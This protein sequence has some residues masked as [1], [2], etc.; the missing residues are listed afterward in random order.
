MTLFVLLYCISQYKGWIGRTGKIRGCN[1][2]NDAGFKEGSDRAVERHVWTFMILWR[3]MKAAVV[4]EELQERGGWPSGLWRGP[5]G[6]WRYHYLHRKQTQ[7]PSLLCACDLGAS[8][9]SDNLFLH[10]TTFLPGQLSN[11]LLSVVFVHPPCKI[12]SLLSWQLVCPFHWHVIAG[13]HLHGCLRCCTVS[14]RGSQEYLWNTLKSW[15]FTFP[16]DS[17]LHKLRHSN[18]ILS[19]WAL[20]VPKH[21]CLF[22]LLHRSSCMCV[23][24]I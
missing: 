3:K 4:C 1:L 18:F 22:L 24:Y 17:L 13:G 8:P 7:G 14:Y 15:A 23:L 5:W 12:P 16:S 20:F 9:A 19:T 6:G 11:H 10:L 2:E 21:W